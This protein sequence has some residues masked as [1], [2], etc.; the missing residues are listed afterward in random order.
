ML[1]CLVEMIYLQQQVGLTAIQRNSDEFSN[2][3][4][5]LSARLK[6][7][8]GPGFWLTDTDA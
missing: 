5:K 3:S 2:N 7:T 8:L 6:W 4:G 1:V